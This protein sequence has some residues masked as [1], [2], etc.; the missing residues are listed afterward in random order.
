MKTK[1]HAATSSWSDQ[2]KSPKWQKKRL[3]IL[4]R[5]DFT[6]QNC[7]DTESTL[8][9]HHKVYTPNTSVWDYADNYLITYCDGC[10]EMA[11]DVIDRLKFAVDDI[12]LYS[13]IE[14]QDYTLRVIY[15]MQFMDPAQA[16]ETY[17]A[18]KLEVTT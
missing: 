11:H 12:K 6:C 13:S 8:H 2:Y 14:V 15:N 3:E 4:N 7:G 17:Y 9:V 10:H 1:K 5:D 18:S 16:G